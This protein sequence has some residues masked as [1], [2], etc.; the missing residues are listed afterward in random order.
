MARACLEVDQVKT[1]AWDLTS[2]PQIVKKMAA[3]TT[4][5]STIIITADEF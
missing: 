1:S 2:R 5:L 4:T 3:R